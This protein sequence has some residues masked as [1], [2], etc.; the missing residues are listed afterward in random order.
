MNPTPLQRALSA[1]PDRASADQVA[2]DH[3]YF[4]FRINALHLGVPAESVR[5]VLRAGPLTPLPRT[6]SFV[7]G[8]T[9][10]RGEVLPVVDLLRFLGKGEVR[11]GPRTRLFVAIAGEITTSVMVDAVVGLNRFK[12]KD[13]LKPPLG[14]DPSSE[15]VMG[16]VKPRNAPQITLLD[17]SKLLV[18]AK[19]RAVKR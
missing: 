10:H 11:Q 19:A 6:A 3:F 2:P 18:A 16:L 5:E 9:G 7:L 13:I 4:C 8:V 14:G 1:A 15:Y 17:F 12:A